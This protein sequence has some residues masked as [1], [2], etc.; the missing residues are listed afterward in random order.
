MSM[1]SKRL[2]I[3]R[4]NV[5]KM[6]T[7]VALL[8]ATGLIGS[9]SAS[10]ESDQTLETKMIQASVEVARDS[11]VEDTEEATTQRFEE[12]LDEEGLGNGV[13]VSHTEYVPEDLGVEILESD[14]EDREGV[15]PDQRYSQS[16]ADFTT[17]SSDSDHS[18][19]DVLVGF[20][21]DFEDAV[22]RD[23][24]N[25]PYYVKD[26]S[27]FNYD[28]NDWSQVGTGTYESDVHDVSWYSGSPGDHGTAFEI[29]LDT[30]RRMTPWGSYQTIPKPGYVSNVINLALEGTPSTLGAHYGHTTAETP[31]GSLSISASVGAFEVGVSGSLGD[32]AFTLSDPIDASDDV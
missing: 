21:A 6:G 25:K 3:G 17:W 10:S 16:A 11:D 31:Y 28:N 13:K 23:R 20:T 15:S 1:K 30:K 9:A 4:R 2:S 18:E 12:I 8:G 27:G 26:G 22:L 7:S 5:L 14:G 24:V 29:E 32:D 19:G